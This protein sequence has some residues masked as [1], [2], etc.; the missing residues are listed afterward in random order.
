MK[1]RNE[2]IIGLI[3]GGLFLLLSIVK[4]VF[5]IPQG[6]F[7]IYRSMIF[8][9]YEGFL[10]YILSL[11]ISQSILYAIGNLFQKQ[12]GDAFL[13]KNK[14]AITIVKKYGY[15][16]LAL[17][18]ACP[19]ISSN[20]ITVS[21][22]IIKMDYKKCILTILMAEIPVIFLYAFL[23]NGFMDNVEFKTY[24]AITIAFLSY[25]IFYLWNRIRN[26]KN[27]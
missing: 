27:C 17:G 19:L 3:F 8:G 6:I 24:I 15:K 22:A 16:V 7:I 11:V 26:L 9:S 14:D 23:G 10:L 4:I 21:A 12:L 5:F 2:I 13:E 18:V 1:K 20:L 25:Y